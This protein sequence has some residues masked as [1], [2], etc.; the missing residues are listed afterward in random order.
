MNLIDDL[1]DLMENFFDGLVVHPGRRYVENMCVDC[2][3]ELRLTFL[4]SLK[5]G[6]CVRCGALSEG[7]IASGSPW[8]TMLVYGERME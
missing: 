8:G 1:N 3:C 2:A 7:L 5:T 6:V 4:A